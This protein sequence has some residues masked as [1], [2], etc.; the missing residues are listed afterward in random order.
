MHEELEEKTVQATAAANS[1]EDL[2]MQ[3]E[4]IKEE[5][6]D[7]KKLIEALDEHV[8]QL[9]AELEAFQHATA[10]DMQLQTT[11]AVKPPET[12]DSEDEDHGEEAN[13]TFD[14][15]AGRMSVTAAEKQEMMAAQ[16]SSDTP[17]FHICP[18][19]I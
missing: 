19:K 3:L 2:Q 14:E 10:A 4:K 12:G 7:D 6:I 17:F 9:E 18:I 1:K 15:T 5:Q 16:V 8:K 11:Q 13:D